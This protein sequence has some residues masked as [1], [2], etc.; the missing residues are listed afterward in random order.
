M[1]GV[2]GADARGA[3]KQKASEESAAVA[4]AQGR[5]D[6]LCLPYP[7]RGVG[8]LRTA[9][10]IV[11]G[12]GAIDMLASRRMGLTSG[13][14]QLREGDGPSVHRSSANFQ[15]WHALDSA[16]ERVALGWPGEAGRPVSAKRERFWRAILCKAT[17]FMLF[18]REETVSSEYTR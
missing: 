8:L 4:R 15:M 7:K 1:S 6:K 14:M 2:V 3:T 5:V 12:S 13:R 10:S 9:P 17:D 11:M 18:G 16:N